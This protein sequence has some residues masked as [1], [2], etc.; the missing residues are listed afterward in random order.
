MLTATRL[1]AA[2]SGMT[3]GSRVN[4]DPNKTVIVVPVVLVR[5]VSQYSS[6]AATPSPAPRTMPVARSRP[7]GARTPIRSMIPAAA[8]LV[9]AK[10]H[11]GLIPIRKEPDPPETLRSARACPA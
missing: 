1:N 10:P 7:R 9:P 5:V 8:T 2:T 4:M 6:S 3:E 11:S